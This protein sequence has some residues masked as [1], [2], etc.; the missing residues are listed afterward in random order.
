MKCMV[1][2]LRTVQELDGACRGLTGKG[3]RV[4]KNSIR[5][6]SGV[7]MQ[8]KN[9]AFNISKAMPIA[10]AVEAVDQQSED[11]TSLI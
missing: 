4:L 7:M 6:K 1:E 2:C 3:S 11:E 9:S 5:L 8:A 10:S